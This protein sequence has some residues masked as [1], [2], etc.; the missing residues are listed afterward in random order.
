MSLLRLI[1]FRQQ[2]EPAVPVLWT[3]AKISTALWLDAADSSTITLNGSN[4]SQWNDKSGNNRHATQSTAADQPIY[5]TANQNGLNVVGFDLDFMNYPNISST[6]T[7]SS[8]TFVVHKRTGLGN[9]LYPPIVS[10]AY[11]SGIYQYLGGSGT[12]WGV[13]DGGLR[14]STELI[15]TDWKIVENIRDKTISPA[16]NF[17]Y[18]NGNAVGSTAL[19]LDNTY[20]PTYIGNDRVSQRSRMD[21]GEI[22]I[23]LDVV[24]TINRQKIEGYLAHKWGL[25]A[26]LPAGHPYKTTPPY[27]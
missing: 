23:T 24:S 7:Y 17:F 12:N 25:T 10:L 3:P 21:I 16:L 4:V 18:S 20:N 27:V 8:S 26:N 9:T 19:S 6:G 2:Q 11:N 1:T 14:Y 5:L 13:Y 22:V 15:G